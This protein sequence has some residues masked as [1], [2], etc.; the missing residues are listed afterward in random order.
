MKRRK[1]RI[2][3][4]VMLKRGCAFAVMD[5]R[6]GLIDCGYCGLSAANDAAF[7][8]R[9]EARIERDRAT[10]LVAGHIPNQRG[11]ESARRRLSLLI[12][13]AHARH[14]GY[15]Q[16]SKAVLVRYFGVA[17]MHERAK[18]VAGRFPEVAP[19]LPP[20]RRLWDPDDERNRI[21]E[22]IAAG[23]VILGPA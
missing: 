8:A 1:L 6:R 2:L 16:V 20:A 21:F 23:L 10:A 12:E 19:R 5:R 14:V 22:A 7:I 4:I 9:I 11:R 3:S 13:L 17:T 15:C 18:I